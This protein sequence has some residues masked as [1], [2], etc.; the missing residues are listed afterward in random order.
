MQ[1][2]EDKNK[3]KNGLYVVSTPIGNLSDI[4]FRAI[5]TLKNSDVILCEDTRVSKKLLSSFDI[6]SKLVAYH[7][8]NEKK[9][10]SKIIKDLELNKIVSIISDAGTPTISDP[11]RILINECLKR[12][13]DVIPIPGASAPSAAISISG[14]SDRYYFHGFLS[15]KKSES[16]K[17]IEFLSKLDSS[18][19]FF[20]SSNKLENFIDLFIK[21]FEDRE[22]LIC[23]EITKM[24]EQFFRLDVKD[25][26]N[27]DLNL[28]GEITLVV[29]QK[30]YKEKNLKL[31]SESDKVKIRK[32]IGK[33]SVKDIV[34]IICESKDLSKK[35]VYNYCLKV[36]NEI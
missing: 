4:T 9:Y 13:I 7:K 33:I 29:S 30:K 3:L 24:Y 2:K 28:K 6:K 15:E 21:F 27:I 23:K 12:Q 10:L 1:I 25:L 20:T 5:Q 31:L 22:I 18:L 19:I 17:D 35:N 8:F 14:F 16:Y 26:N 36:K 11:G 34:D 32:L